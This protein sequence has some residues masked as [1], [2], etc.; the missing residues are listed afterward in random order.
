[1]E[2]K[3]STV[4]PYEANPSSIP[5]HAPPMQTANSYGSAPGQ[6]MVQ[7]DIYQ[8]PQQQP[9]SP[10]H[11]GSPP[12]INNYP[13]QPPGSPPIES[14]HYAQPQM[15]GQ[16][17]PAPM[18]SPAANAHLEHPKGDYYSSQQQQQIPMQHMQTGQMM[19]PMQGQTQYHSAVP[20]HLLQRTAMAVDCPVCRTRAITRTELHSGNTT[21]AWA[22]VICCIFALGCIPYLVDSLKDVDHKCGHCGVALAT[23]HR[24]GHTEVHARQ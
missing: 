12:P 7:H 1:M 24:S 17:G 20:I 18:A 6:P 4:P 11:T 3:T 9:V 10:M 13:N 15:M 22:L 14:A 16:M 23:W 2:E 21:H 8:A 19:Q 5:Q